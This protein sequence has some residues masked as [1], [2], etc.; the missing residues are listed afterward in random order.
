MEN[1]ILDREIDSEMANTP[2]LTPTAYIPP[3]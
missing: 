1:Y 2:F 3:P